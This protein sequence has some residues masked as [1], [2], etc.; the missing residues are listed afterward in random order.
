MKIALST[1]LS[2]ILVIGPATAAEFSINDALREA[3]KSHPGVR[4][5]LNFAR[6]VSHL[7]L[8][9]EGVLFDQP[10]HLVVGQRQPQHDAIAAG[11]DLRGAQKVGQVLVLSLLLGLI[12]LVYQRQLHQLGQ[13]V[14]II[15]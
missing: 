13:R 14:G 6:I 5:N 4:L 12:L 1:I 2:L 3:A 15:G 9:G 10:G 7:H 11:V 8:Q